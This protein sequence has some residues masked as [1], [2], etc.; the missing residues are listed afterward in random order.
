MEFFKYI[1][2]SSFSFYSRLD[3][4]LPEMSKEEHSSAENMSLET[5]KN[6]SS[7]DLFDEI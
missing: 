6:S 3:P 2:L 7:E 5:L 4:P 1:K